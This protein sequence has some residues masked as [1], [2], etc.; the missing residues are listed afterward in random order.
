MPIY[1]TDN[2]LKNLEKARGR[3][4]DQF[5]RSLNLVGREQAEFTKREYGTDRAATGHG[6][7][8]RSGQLRRTITYIVQ[9]KQ[10]LLICWIFA[11]A[12]YAVYVEHMS[13]GKYAFLLPALNERKQKIWEIIKAEMKGVLK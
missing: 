7:T 1:G 6:F 8:S 13:A 3:I 10:N 4:N 11:G 2:V 5:E 9:K 12:I